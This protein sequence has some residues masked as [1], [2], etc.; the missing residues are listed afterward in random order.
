MHVLEHSL[1]R[2]YLGGLLDLHQTHPAVS[3]HR[4][5]LMVTEPGDLD[6]HLFTGLRGN[7]QLEYVKNK[8]PTLT[9]TNHAYLEHYY[10]YNLTTQTMAL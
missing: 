1:N 10:L 5:S 2:V 7:I 6:A 4:Q 3:C 9:V 8:P